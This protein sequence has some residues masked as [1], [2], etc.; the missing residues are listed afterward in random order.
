[1]NSVRKGGRVLVFGLNDLARA[2]I[3]EAAISYGEVKIEGVY[4]AKGTFPLALQLLERNEFGFDRLITHQ[5]EIDR[6]WEAVELSRSGE[7]VK[8]LIIT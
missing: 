3:G 6:F 1:M 7:A 5:L 2:E 4:I 8:A